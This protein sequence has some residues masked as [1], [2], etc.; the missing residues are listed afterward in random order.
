MSKLVRFLATFSLFS[1][2]AVSSLASATNYTLWVN[3]RTGGGVIGDYTSFSYW[4]PATT[5]AG[6]NKKAVN[7]DGVSH[8]SDQNYR[9]RNALDCYCTGSN[10]C[11][12]AAHS[13]GDLHIG[14]ALALYGTTTR[15]VTNATPGSTGT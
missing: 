3:G 10:W 13:A 6:V 1:L 7:W 8:V 11:Y 5:A 15:A 14:Y 12:V 4:G 9:I 2:L